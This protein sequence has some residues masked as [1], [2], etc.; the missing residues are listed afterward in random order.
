MWVCR[1]EL[2]C[3]FPPHRAGM[4]RR[5]RAGE[6]NIYREGGREERQSHCSHLDLVATVVMIVGLLL[7][8]YIFY[9][10]LSVN[11]NWCHYL[12]P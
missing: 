2:D 4:I 8:C 7:L 5:E 3:Q 6:G 12:P 10:I 11:K 1:W 9:L